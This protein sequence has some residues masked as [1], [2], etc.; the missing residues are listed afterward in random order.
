MIKKLMPVFLALALLCG[1]SG[2]GTRPEETTAGSSGVE[3]TAAAHTSGAPE[4]SAAAELTDRLISEIGEIDGASLSAINRAEHAF[5]ALT[6]AE[7]AL[8]KNSGMLTEAREKYD[9][10]TS[11]PRRGNAI[12]RTKLQFGTYCFYDSLWNDEGV[13]KLA[14][15]GIDILTAQNYDDGLLALCEKYGVKLLVN[16]DPGEKA[17]SPAVCGRHIVDE[18]LAG[19]FENVGS[20]VEK[21]H[22]DY[23]DL[24]AY[25]NLHPSS[26]GG[27]GVPNYYEYIQKYIECIPTDYISY[28]H[29]VYWE[30]NTDKKLWFNT[31]GIVSD[32][33]LKSDRDFWIVVQVS[34]DDYLTGTERPNVTSWG[35]YESDQPLLSERQLSIQAYTSL[36][37]GAK[38]INWACWMAGWWLPDNQVVDSNGN[39]TA[40]YD[41]LKA[42]T[43]EIDSFSDVYS[44][45]VRSSTE[46]IGWEDCRENSFSCIAGNSFGDF[47]QRAFSA[48]DI[49]DGGSAVAGFFEKADG[50]SYAMT[51]CNTSDFYDMEGSETVSFRSPF[52]LSVTAYVAGEKRALS[53]DGEGRYT[54]ELGRGC[55]AFV[56]VELDENAA[57]R[58]ELAAQTPRE[59]TA[60][61]KGI[62]FGIYTFGS[63]PDAAK[64]K[65]FAADGFDFI[66]DNADAGVMSALEAEGMGIFALNYTDPE[67]PSGGAFLGYSASNPFKY[68]DFF[69]VE[70]KAAARGAALLAPVP[71]TLSDI[72]G[73]ASGMSGDLMY[74]R[75]NLSLYNAGEKVGNTRFIPALAYAG[76]YAADSGRTLCASIGTVERRSCGLC[77]PSAD[78]LRWEVGALLTFGVRAVVF[79]DL[80]DGALYAAARDAIA[81]AAPAAEALAGCA[82]KGTFAEKLSGVNSPKVSVKGS[83]D[84]V[85]ALAFLDSLSSD[86]EMIFGLFEGEGTS[87]ISLLP[88]GGFAGSASIKLDGTE[89]SVTLCCGGTT[90]TITPENGVYTV[91]LSEPGP[92]FVIIK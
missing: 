47:R 12:D 56:T 14:E 6:D 31:F 23:P 57:F 92:A 36:A 33:C 89:K 63:H 32:A 59:K 61:L 85:K 73:Y 77:A 15:C 19:A 7:R 26:A 83:A 71:D 11:E 84:A 53:P 54:I 13:R 9:A 43:G 79:T 24:V 44:E 16:G 50:S 88:M 75:T 45:Y 40:L 25:V 18:P 69:N 74:L 37:F 55:G 81:D 39:Y 65:T 1:C 5:A 86:G 2:G 10:L 68:N 20:M 66:I 80:S 17:S 28:D 90:R 21:A 82:Y 35:T 78:E 70:E 27:L 60:E 52:A 58:A 62:S 91:S 87:V 29:Y 34:N 22:A 41:E 38:V 30:E 42:L 64:I 51:V 72:G 46:A 76:R 3:T 48:L 8:V 4:G 49:S 67:Y